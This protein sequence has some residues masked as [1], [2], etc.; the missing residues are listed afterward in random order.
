MNHNKCSDTVEKD[1]YVGMDFNVNFLE[2]Q[3]AQE[4][5]LSNNSVT[6]KLNHSANFM[7]GSIMI[8]EPVLLGTI[9]MQNGTSF[10]TSF[11]KAQVYQAFAQSI[12]IPLLMLKC[13][14]RNW[15]CQKDLTT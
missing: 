5:I 8:T 2:L 13:I 1:L 4:M 7:E 11:D 15:V 12:Q 3:A 10:G 9:S 6:Y 14:D